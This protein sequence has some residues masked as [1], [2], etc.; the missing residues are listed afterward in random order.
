MPMVEP[1]IA[2]AAIGGELTA[3]PATHKRARQRVL[4]ERKICPTPRKTA[5]TG[6]GMAS[7][8]NENTWDQ[9]S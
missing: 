1:A 6:V 9:C 7:R 4:P 8:G 5:R 2:A 3:I